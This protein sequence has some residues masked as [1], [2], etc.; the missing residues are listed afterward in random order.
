LKLDTKGDASVILDDIARTYDVRGNRDTTN[1]L[2]TQE[3]HYRTF[4]GLWGHNV[5]D[6]KVSFEDF[7]AYYENVSVA[8]A[9]DAEFSEMITACW[10]L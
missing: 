6:A 8:Y 9:T 4:M 7:V 10:G 5:A 1:G 2:R 3:Q